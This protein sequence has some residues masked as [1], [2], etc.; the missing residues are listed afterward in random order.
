MNY[1]ND[2]NNETDITEAGKTIRVVYCEPGKYARV[3]EIGN[4]LEDLQKAVGGWI[5]TFYGLDD[6]DCCV[7]CNDE[8]KYNGMEP[9]R[10]MYDED[11]KL[12]DI[13]FG[14]FFICDCRTEEFASLSD[15]QIEKYMAQFE[16]PEMLIR[17]LSEGIKMV[18]Y[19][20]DR[21]MER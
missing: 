5:E 8:S 6:P 13:I 7:V 14:P 18:P 20:P 12:M 9:C 19:S 21:D 2:F 11:G 16:R 17:N 15:A 1:D 10:A 3:I 4:E